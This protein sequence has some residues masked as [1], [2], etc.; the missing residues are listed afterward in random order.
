M[1]ASVR[2]MMTRMALHT[3][4][5]AVALIVALHFA[6]APW[7]HLM[8]YAGAWLGCALA[9]LGLLLC[10]ERFVAFIDDRIRRIVA[11]ERLTT[12]LLDYQRR[13]RFVRVWTQRRTRDR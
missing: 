9:Y 7:L 8:L 5:T 12:E 6:G 13:L 2:L 3:I 11:E 10:R 4:G 1:T